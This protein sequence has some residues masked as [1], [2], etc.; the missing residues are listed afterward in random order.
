MVI[1]PFSKRNLR[2]IKRI[3]SMVERKRQ[4]RPAMKE[5]NNP[6]TFQ[7]PFEAL[8][9]RVFAE[10]STKI[11][12]A[13][14][15]HNM[16]ENMNYQWVWQHGNTET[17]S[18]RLFEIPLTKLIA[19]ERKKIMEG[20]PSQVSP[21]YNV[22]WIRQMTRDFNDP[23]FVHFAYERDSINQQVKVTIHVGNN[24]TPEKVRKRLIEFLINRNFGETVRKYNADSAG[25]KMKP[26]RTK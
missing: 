4:R 8:R 17:P 5:W 14:Q 15:Y 21:L 13:S 26:H 12:T 9:Q 11:L 2:R 20:K 3:R 1:T 23:N 24:V 7:A 6:K 25:I 22:P 19:H 16:M 18:N 10:L